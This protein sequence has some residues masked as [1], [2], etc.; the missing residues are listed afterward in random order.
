[1][2]AWGVG[3]FDND[4][5]CDWK[6]D[7]E[8]TN[9][10]RVVAATLGAVLAVGDDFLDSDEACNG[11]AACEVIARLKGNWGPRNAYTES[12]D[13]WVLTHPQPPPP[14]TVRDAVAVID[15]VLT[16]PSELMELWSDNTAWEEG[17]KDLRKRV[18][19]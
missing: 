5:A 6:Y 10:L 3:T 14:E 9:D 15:R 19:E 8:Q 2:G 17:V 7:L 13:K 18:E 11:L 12:V 1:M 4:A 16:E